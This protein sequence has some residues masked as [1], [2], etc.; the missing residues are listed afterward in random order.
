LERPRAKHGGGGGNENISNGCSGNAIALTGNACIV[1]D[2]ILLLFGHGSTLDF[3]DD[4]VDDDDDNDDGDDT[5]SEEDDEDDAPDTIE[6]V[7]DAI[8]VFSGSLAGPAVAA[9]SI[10]H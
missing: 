5:V 8:L 9:A 1:D 6:S 4:E 7:G 10:A 2:A 3:D